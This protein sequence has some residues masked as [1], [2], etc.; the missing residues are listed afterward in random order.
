MSISSFCFLPD[1]RSLLEKG[2]K[3]IIPVAI[4]YPD[5][6]AMT[7]GDL[8]HGVRTIRDVLHANPTM[9]HI[10]RTIVSQVPIFLFI[11]SLPFFSSSLVFTSGH[12][13]YCK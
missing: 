3:R 11:Q 2:Q 13:L 10:I 9:P 6:I 12:D 4:L 1:E 5:N 7:H 8:R